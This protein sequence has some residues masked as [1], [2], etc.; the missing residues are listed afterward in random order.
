MAASSLTENDASALLIESMPESCEGNSPQESETCLRV[1]VTSTSDFA[2]SQSFED[3]QRT[4][5]S[6]LRVS[7]ADVSN[8]S[9]LRRKK[10]RTNSSRETDLV[11]SDEGAAREN[12]T[13]AKA[14]D[15][16]RSNATTVAIVIPEAT[17]TTEGN[18]PI[19]TTVI[20]GN[21]EEVR[22]TSANALQTANLLA[23]E[24]ATRQWLGQT[25]SN[26]QQVLIS[27]T[28][29][30]ENA[31]DDATTKWLSSDS[32]A[33]QKEGSL[34]LNC[35]CVEL[36]RDNG[37]GIANVDEDQFIGFSLIMDD[38]TSDAD[39][40][41]FTNLPPGTYFAKFYSMTD[42]SVV[43]TPVEQSIDSD[44]ITESETNALRGAIA[45]DEGNQENN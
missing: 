36:Y 37:D 40:Y 15:N 39:H 21:N 30:D 12:L 43:S 34:G 26:G 20:E 8:T 7:N 42:S 31:Q 11:M 9:S 16:F 28:S 23:C 17:A 13:T 4:N 24:M 38:S 6:V 32:E 2:T 29:A 41:Q 18:E 27:T 14:F 35:V 45:I 22:D 1:N 33:V 19:V 5:G 10:N 44:M 3:E 25:A